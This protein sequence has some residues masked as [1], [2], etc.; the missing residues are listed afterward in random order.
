MKLDNNSNELV[1]SV[2]II[3]YALIN[4]DLKLF[5]E[6]FIFLIFPIAMESLTDSHII[7]Y[8]NSLSYKHVE[9]FRVLFFSCKQETLF[10]INVQNCG[11]FLTLCSLHI[12]KLRRR[13]IAYDQNFLSKL[14][15]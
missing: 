5:W 1:S 11:H 13:Y 9:V 3:G 12:L 14:C 2:S 6:M 8:V 7:T 4:L 15:P 10:L